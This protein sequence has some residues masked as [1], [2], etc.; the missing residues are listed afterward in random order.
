MLLF[1]LLFQ[2]YSSEHVE[3]EVP[4]V[5]Q[6]QPPSAPSTPQITRPVSPTPNRF[7]LTE[8]LDNNFETMSIGSCRST[9]SNGEENEYGGEAP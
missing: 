3:A 8:N 9:R 7:N 2:T 4:Q 6:T 5:A 1:I